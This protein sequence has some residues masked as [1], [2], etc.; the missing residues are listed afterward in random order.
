VKDKAASFCSLFPGLAS[1]EEVIDI[2]C[3]LD[4]N[5]F[6]VLSPGSAR[7]LAGLYL[8]VSLLNHSCVTNCRLIFR[9]DSCLQVRASLEIKRGQQVNIS[10]TPPFFS[11]IAR[12]NILHR[13]KQFLCFCPRCEDPSE[14]GTNLSSVRCE[15]GDCEKLLG[16]YQHTGAFSE[17]WECSQCKRRINYQQYAALDAKYLGIQTRL[18]KENVEEMKDI[19]RKHSDSLSPCHALI[20]ET[21]QHLAAALGRVDGYRLDQLSE[22]DTDLK[23]SISYDL[24][25]TLDVLEPGMSKSRGITLLDLA[26]V[27]IRKILRNNNLQLVYNQLLEVEKELSEANDILKYEDEKAL[28]GNVAKKARLDLVEI[29]NYL[30]SLKQR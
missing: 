2:L 13:G 16:V 18:D 12:N 27:R 21:K 29:R 7:T 1:E 26:E 10:Y 14:L 28:E 23:I 9:S 17:D 30:Q 15:A 6:Q 3:I 5:T 11:V 8:R 4:T 25:R 20:M 19:L 22:Q 24:L